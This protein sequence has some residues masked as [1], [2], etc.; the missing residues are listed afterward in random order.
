MEWDVPDRPESTDPK[1]G[2]DVP[3]VARV[4]AGDGSAY[5]ELVRRYQ[6]QAVAVAYRL[7]GKS[8]DAADVAQDA[9]LRAYRSIDQLSDPARFGP[10]L[11]Q[12]VRNLSLNYRRSRKSSATVTWDDVLETADSFRSSVGTAIESVMPADAAGGDELRSAV[13]VAIDGLP[14]QQRMSLVLF[15]VEGVPQKEVARMLGCSVALVKWNVF[16]ARKALKDALADFLE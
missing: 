15:S 5:D 10:W 2:L 6:R 11:M 4:V 7:L 16:Q 13:A 1:G 14:E 8:E 12:I 9:F 3:L